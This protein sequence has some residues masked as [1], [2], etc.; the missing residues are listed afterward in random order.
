MARRI[1]TAFWSACS[2]WWRP[3]ARTTSGLTTKSSS[4][5]PGAKMPSAPKLAVSDSDSLRRVPTWPI[6]SWATSCATTASMIAVGWRMSP[7]VK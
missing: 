5:T 2:S 1:S 6:T 7:S 4:P 3:K